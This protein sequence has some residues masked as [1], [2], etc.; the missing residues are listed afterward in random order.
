M[1]HSEQDR[2][3]HATPVTVATAPK[4]GLAWLLRLRW[5]AIFGQL[6]ITGLAVL[7]LGISLPLGL[8]LAL[9]GFTALSNF[10]LTFWLRSGEPSS[11]A[12]FA[13]LVLDILILTGLLLSAGGASNPFSVFYLVHVALSALLLPP[14]RAWLVTALTSLAFALLFVLPSHVIDPHAMHMLHGA[15]SFHLQGMWLA[16]SLAA[17]FV[18][19]FVSRVASSLQARER[20]LFELQR[21]AARTE[22]LASLSTLAAGAAH[23]LG[24]PLG[25]IALVAKELERGLAQGREPAELSEDARLIRQEVERCRD[26]LQ[27]MAANAGE[28]AGEMPATVSISGLE[29][30]L[31]DTLGPAGSQLAFER[32]GEPLD[33]V[34]PKRLLLQVLVNLVRNAFDAQ[35]EAGSSDP[36]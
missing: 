32:S 7:V 22:K 13:V 16:Y 36:V 12:L 26:I 1:H 28:S 33:L 21:S 18:V 25:T 17:G 14:R 31:S 5:L 34:L 29:R 4:I 3:A 11:R 6:T 10:A 20:E 15:S 27:R 30:S 35:A 19:H 23:E 8:V 9:I 24:T 2:A